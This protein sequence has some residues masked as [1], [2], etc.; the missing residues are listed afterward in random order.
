MGADGFKKLSYDE[1][2]KMF[3][4]L[5]YAN[6]EAEGSSNDESEKSD[7]V[8]IEDMPEGQKALQLEKMRKLR[9]RKNSIAK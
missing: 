8:R 9:E 7:E 1:S 6:Q 5:M 4:Y 3:D 2:N